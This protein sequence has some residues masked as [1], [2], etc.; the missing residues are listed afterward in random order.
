MTHNKTLGELRSHITEIDNDILRLIS[1]R[2]DVVLDIYRLKRTDGAD[3]RDY[4]REKEVLENAVANAESLGLPTELARD[5]VEHL[6]AHSLALQEKEVVQEEGTGSG[7]TALVIGGLGKIGLWFVRF[8]RSQ[9]FEVHIADPSVQKET[10]VRRRE[11]EGMALDHDIIVVAVPLGHCAS[12]LSTLAERKPAGL[13]FDVAS[14]KSPVTDAIGQLQ[15]AGCKVTSLHPMFGPDTDMLGGKHVIFMNTGND[16]AVNEARELFAHTMAT[17]VE[18]TLKEHDKLVAYV[19]GLSHLLNIGFFTA[20]RNSGEQAERL[21]QISST[22]FDAQLEVAHR[23][24][25]ENPHL[26]YE[27]Q[28]LN[29]FRHDPQ[30]ALTGALREIIDVIEGDDELAFV[31]IMEEGRK[32][33][34]TLPYI[35]QNSPEP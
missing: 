32:Y 8:L 15:K 10:P 2:L 3:L 1:R 7:R 31:K 6:I 33:L 16:D 17:C 5:V 35:Q 25:V 18:M 12:I 26:Y 19:L 24:S 30:K 11:W 28:R 23:I 14:L 27:I 22:S 29:E 34:Q 13:I 20:L 21:H 4:S 9:G